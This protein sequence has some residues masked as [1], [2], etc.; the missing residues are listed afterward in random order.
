[1]ANWVYYRKTA[2]VKIVQLDTLSFIIS[3]PFKKKE[4]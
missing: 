2:Q 4:G 1:M 3:K